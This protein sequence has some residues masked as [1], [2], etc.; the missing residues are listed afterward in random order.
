MSDSE[1]E[2][3]VGYIVQ[4]WGVRLEVVTS[5]VTVGI[6]IKHKE[7]RLKHLW[8]DT[9][10]PTESFLYSSGSDPTLFTSSYDRQSIAMTKKESGSIRADFRLLRI[11]GMKARNVKELV[12]VYRDLGLAKLIDQYRSR[13]DFTNEARILL[14]RILLRNE[15]LNTTFSG[16]RVGMTEL[17]KLA[18]LISNNADDDIINTIIPGVLDV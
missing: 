14:R 4:T 15:R 11:L 6:N 7:A 13:V 17:I 2:L 12:E 18:E 10:D 3:K 8:S 9:K 5:I 1:R 16:T